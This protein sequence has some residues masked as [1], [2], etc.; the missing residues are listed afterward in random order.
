MK[1]CTYLFSALGAGGIVLSGC[2]V[3]STGQVLET[4]TSSTVKA[5]VCDLPA[6]SECAYKDFNGADLSGYMLQNA[7]LQFADLQGVNLEGAD[8]TQANLAG[9][10]LQS[11]NLRNAKLIGANLHGANLA[12]ASLVGAILQSAKTQYVNFNGAD[13][14]GVYLGGLDFTGSIFS[15]A[16]I[17]ADSTEL[18]SESQNNVDSSC[19]KQWKAARSESL[20]DPSSDTQLRGTLWACSSTEEWKHEARLVGEYSSNLLDAACVLVPDAPLCS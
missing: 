2:S 6:L 8:L 18:I 17:D 10:N 5:V 20:S 9:A 14:T 4:S 19:R 3:A 15:N 12:T 1:I 7:S 13:L 16:K 11:A